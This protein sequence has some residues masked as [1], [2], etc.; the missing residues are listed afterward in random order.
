M[1]TYTTHPGATTFVT[2]LLPDE[3]NTYYFV[4]RARDEAR[5][6]DTNDVE[7]L[8]VNLCL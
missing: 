1:P 5:N 3:G 2:P 4:V 8:G 7:R 6:R